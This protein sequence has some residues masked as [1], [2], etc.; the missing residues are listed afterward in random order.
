[1]CGPRWMWGPNRSLF[2]SVVLHKCV[3][4]TPLSQEPLGPYWEPLGAQKLPKA[5]PKLAKVSPKAP[6]SDPI[7]TH[8][9]LLGALGALLG[10]MGAPKEPHAKKT[11]ENTLFLEP[12]SL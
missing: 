3:H 1:M 6:Q 9:G 8:W 7:G 12:S 10:A 4:P 11:H 2:K 5:P